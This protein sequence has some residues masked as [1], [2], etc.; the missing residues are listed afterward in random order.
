[1]KLPSRLK[2]TNN[3]IIITE[4]SKLERAIKKKLKATQP[5]MSDFNSHI[6]RIFDSTD[7]ISDLIPDVKTVDDVDNLFK[8]L[9]KKR[10]WGVEDV[11]KLKS[12]ADMFLD[13]EDFQEMQKMIQE[14]KSH[15]SGYRATTKII[16]RIQADE[17]KENESDDDDDVEYES[18]ASNPKK[19]NKRYRKELSVKLFKKRST[20]QG[21][22]EKDPVGSQNVLLKMESLE[23]I[24]KIWND[25]CD[26]FD[27]SLTAVLDSIKDGCIEVTW[28]IPS[29][30]ALKILKHISRAV[31]FLQSRFISY[32]RLENILIYC[33]SSGAASQKVRPH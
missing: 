4:Y 22:G 16:E 25:L 2:E 15:L 14:Y 13:K 8:V 28:W 24:E 19:Y 6:L 32:I 20:G 21:A 3:T 26:E 10:L 31:E 30:S 7:N 9:T 23:Y 1:M 33:E 29:P 12:I 5:D 27:I 11:S 18:V 17:I